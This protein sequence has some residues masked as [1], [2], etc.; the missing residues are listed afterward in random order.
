LQL[1]GDNCRASTITGAF[2]LLVKK[3]S[4]SMRLFI[5]A[6]LTTLVAACSSLPRYEEPPAGARE[7]HASIESSGSKLSLCGITGSPI[8]ESRVNVIDGK[9]VDFFG[10]AIRVSAG[11]RRI[12]LACIAKR[13]LAIGAMV[14]FFRMIDVVLAEGGKYRVE[15]RWENDA[16][17]MSLVE[18]GSG[19][20]VHAK[21]VAAQP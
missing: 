17:R 1:G 19:K 11:P 18:A 4:K 12:Q 7:N 10:S 13:G 16:C 5:V 20:E 8:C 6:L 14:G 9:K 15:S 21:D 2:L 3:E